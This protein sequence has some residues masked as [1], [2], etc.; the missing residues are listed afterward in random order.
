MGSRWAESVPGELGV[1]LNSEG[2]HSVLEENELPVYEGGRA[3]DVWSPYWGASGTEIKQ[4]SE[5]L[6]APKHQHL[7]QLYS[8]PGVPRNVKGPPR[9]PEGCFPFPCSELGS[10]GGPMPC[11]SLGQVIYSPFT[12]EFFCPLHFQQG[13]LLQ[14]L[15]SELLRT[16][17]PLA[18]WGPRART[19]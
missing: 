3:R 17:G 9:P 1:N 6:S 4:D 8:T 15:H 10:W 5:N 11:L 19:K 12:T 18:L 14:V 16:E 7:S 2:S 13:L